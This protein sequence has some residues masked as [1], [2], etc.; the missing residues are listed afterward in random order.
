MPIVTAYEALGTDGLKHSLLETGARAIFVDVHLLPTLTTTL[1]SNP[2]LELQWLI[3]N[4]G[5]HIDRNNAAFE[6]LDKLV[7]TY[8]QFQIVNFEQLRQLGQDSPVD[9]VPPTREDL[10]AI[11]YTSG[12]TGTPKG[13]P[14]KHKAVIASS[15]PVCPLVSTHEIEY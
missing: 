5:N 7:E 1:K 11:Y 6:D 13:V 2:S 9:S 12:S 15:T 14:I 4:H 10:F 3:V 8:P